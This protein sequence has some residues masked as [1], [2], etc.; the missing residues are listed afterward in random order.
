MG[1]PHLRFIIVHR[2]SVCHCIGSRK[3]QR[4]PAYLIQKPMVSGLD[5]TSPSSMLTTPPGSFHVEVQAS[6]QM[7][8]PMTPPDW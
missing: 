5:L 7:L 8:A 2:L 1:F 6:W 3:I 4:N